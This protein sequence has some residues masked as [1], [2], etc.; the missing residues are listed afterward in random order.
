MNIIKKNLEFNYEIIYTKD[1]LDESANIYY[2]ISIVLR[3][4]NIAEKLLTKI[5]KQ[6]L[7]LSYFPKANKVVFSKRNEA[8]HRLIV[9][10]YAIFYKIDELKKQI[11]IL[12]IFNTRQNYL[13]F[14]FKNPYDY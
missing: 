5:R 4:Q 1:Y 13:N 14:I 9:K 8:V 6:V 3:E 7:G 12:H 11:F 10:K 2:Y